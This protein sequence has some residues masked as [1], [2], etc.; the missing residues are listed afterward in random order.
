VGNQ[1]PGLG[2]AYNC[3]GV[4]PVNEITDFFVFPCLLLSYHKFLYPEDLMT[5]YITLI[6]KRT[7]LYMLIHVLRGHIWDKEKVAL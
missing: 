6:K 2:Q 3:G 1:D 7:N 4:K 5:T